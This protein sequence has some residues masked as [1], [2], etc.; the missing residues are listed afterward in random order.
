MD[1]VPGKLQKVL[2][3]RRQIP[4]EPCDRVVLAIGVVVALLRPCELV[5]AE[6]HRDALRQKESG[7]EISHLTRAQFPDIGLVCRPFLA[8]IPADVVVRPVPVPLTVVDRMEWPLSG[9][10]S[11]FLERGRETGCRIGHPPVRKQ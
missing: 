4:V 3:I 9:L 2:L 8:A 7:K 6:N 5:P 1:Q 10:Y 11:A